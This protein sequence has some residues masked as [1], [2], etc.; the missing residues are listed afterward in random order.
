MREDRIHVPT[1]DGL[2]ETTVVWPEGE[3]PFP[4]VVMYHH[5]GGLHEGILGMARRLASY[6]YCVAVPSLYWRVGTV[7]IDA[8]NKDPVSMQLRGVVV[9]TTEVPHQVMNDTRCLLDFMKQMR[10]V[11]DG[12]RGTIGYCL[13]GRF[14]VRAACVY[15]EEITASASMYGV[16]LIAEGPESLDRDLASLRGS[17]YLAFAATDQHVSAAEVET[18]TKFFRSE[19]T[20]EWEVETLAGT[21]HGF[22]FPGRPM[23]DFAAAERTWLKSLEIFRKELGA[24]LDVRG[25]RP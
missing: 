3:G 7:I 22:S 6:G 18:I 10:Q 24:G 8:D 25:T 16:D 21:R 17:T 14:A 4:G 23:F 12:P 19:C 20:A 13:G 15:P 1:P 9:K 5:I 11:D 2:M